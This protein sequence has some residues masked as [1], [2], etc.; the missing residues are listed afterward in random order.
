[1][2]PEEVGL[3]NKKECLLFIRGIKPFL[4]KKFPLEKHIN[5]KETDD[6]NSKNT[7]DHYKK[8]EDRKEENQKTIIEQMEKN[9]VEVIELSEED[10]ENIE[11]EEI[12]G[13]I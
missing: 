12:N 1:M 2:T 10:L 11:L 13:L 5:F 8:T 4:S 6:Y 3:L 7:Y 9:V